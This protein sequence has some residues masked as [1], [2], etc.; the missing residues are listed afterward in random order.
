MECFVRAIHVGP[1]KHRLLHSRRSIYTGI[2]ELKGHEE[3]QFGVSL[4]HSPIF[5]HSIRLIY[6][7]RL[8]LEES[9]MERLITVKAGVSVENRS[10]SLR[11]VNHR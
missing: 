5:L 6:D 11:T 4:P 10:R 7:L 3:E 8:A 9:N 1:T 2:E